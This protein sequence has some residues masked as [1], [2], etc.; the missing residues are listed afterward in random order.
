MGWDW[1]SRTTRQIVNQ[2]KNNDNNGRNKGSTKERGRLLFKSEPRRVRESSNR[3]PT[4]T[5]QANP[6]Q[7][8]RSSCIH[9]L[10]WMSKADFMLKAKV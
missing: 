4:Q 8:R 10:V 6:T 2:F 1:V 3:V 7:A 9:V 5:R